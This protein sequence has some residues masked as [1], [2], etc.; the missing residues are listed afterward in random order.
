LN[1]IGTTLSFTITNPAANPISFTDVAVTD[2]LP[3]GLVLATPSSGLTTTCAGLTL[4]ITAPAGG[5]TITASG[6]TLAAGASCTISVQVL[7]AALG[8]WTNTSPVV[9]VG[10]TVVGNTAYA[11]ISVVDQFF[12]WFF[13]EGGAEAKVSRNPEELFGKRGVAQFAQ[14]H[15]FGSYN[16]R[17]V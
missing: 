7:G 1:F 9:A 16:K 6:I 14:C 5:S 17:R 4:S 8:T 12:T 3:A 10:G 15:L 2:T 11:R 13:K